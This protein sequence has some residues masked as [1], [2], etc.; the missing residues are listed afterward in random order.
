MNHYL[1]NEL[2]LISSYNKKKCYSFLKN[3]GT[4]ILKICLIVF[5]VIFCT[6]QRKFFKNIKKPEDILDIE[7]P[8]NTPSK[9]FYDYV[10]KK[11]ML[12]KVNIEDENIVHYISRIYSINKIM[13]N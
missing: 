2:G 5:Q 12:G 7:F 9:Q 1:G 8:Y 6:N 11:Q 4:S 10:L 3:V 13:K